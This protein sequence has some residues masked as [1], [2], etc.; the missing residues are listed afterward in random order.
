MN[1]G[2]RSEVRV[3]L[4]K[5]LLVFVVAQGAFGLF[6]SWL[7]RRSSAECG[8]NTLLFVLCAGLTVTMTMSFLAILQIILGREKDA[9]P[10]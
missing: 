1:A 9:R 3:S 6:G 5:R 2:A 4:R 10:P 7:Y 8:P